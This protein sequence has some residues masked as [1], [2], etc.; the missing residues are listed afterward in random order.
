MFFLLFDMVSLQGIG[1]PGRILDVQEIYYPRACPE[2]AEG[3][4]SWPKTTGNIWVKTG[5][6]LWVKTPGI[7]SGEK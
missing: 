1:C 4:L 6:I 5:G 3:W 2:L 7:L